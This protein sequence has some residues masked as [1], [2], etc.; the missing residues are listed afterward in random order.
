MKR[1]KIQPNDVFN[2]S[3][4]IT[5]EGTKQF[6]GVYKVLGHSNNTT[7]VK[8]LNFYEKMAVFIKRSFKNKPSK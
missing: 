6:D 5:I 4:Q 1:L 2:T 8:T 7:H 3:E